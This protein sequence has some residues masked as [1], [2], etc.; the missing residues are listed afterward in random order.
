MCIQGM[1][2]NQERKGT[3]LILAFRKIT[4]TNTGSSINTKLP[5]VSTI[6]I[7][8]CELSNHLFLLEDEKSHKF[9]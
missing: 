1:M 3:R 6:Y 8:I 7:L 5:K 4:I 9:I 2:E